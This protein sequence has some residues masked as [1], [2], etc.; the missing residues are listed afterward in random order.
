M[1]ESSSRGSI[2]EFH[3]VLAKTHIKIL[4]EHW[5]WNIKVRASDDKVIK[6]IP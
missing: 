4:K 3:R 5:V 1:K 2:K 6:M